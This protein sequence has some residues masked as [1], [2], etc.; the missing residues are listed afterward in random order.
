MPEGAG[1]GHGDTEDT[2]GAVR[3]A[4][5]TGLGPLPLLDRFPAERRKP[6][7]PPLH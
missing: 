3:C 4:W 6:V 2:E 1:I 5:L 7:S